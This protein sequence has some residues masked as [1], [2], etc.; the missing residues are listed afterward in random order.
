MSNPLSGMVSSVPTVLQQHLKLQQQTTQPT[1]NYHHPRKSANPKKT[2]Q[3]SGV[4]V[5]IAQK[6]MLGPHLSLN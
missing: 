3:R 4:Q 1:A 5:R 6:D 2:G